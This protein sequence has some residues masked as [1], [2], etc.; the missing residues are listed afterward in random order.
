[1]KAKNAEK[2]DMKMMRTCDRG[3]RFKLTF[4]YFVYFIYLLSAR[5]PLIAVRPLLLC[6][7][8]AVHI[9]LAASIVRR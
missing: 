7:F 4:V 3:V 5:W 8:G 2:N 1:M 9:L 6:I